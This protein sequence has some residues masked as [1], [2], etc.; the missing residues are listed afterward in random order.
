M[1]TFVLTLESGLSVVLD[2]H[3]DTYAMTPYE[4]LALGNVEGAAS[5]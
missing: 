3:T 2:D 4:R 1:V 5:G